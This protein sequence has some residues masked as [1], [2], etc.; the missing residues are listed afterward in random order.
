MDPFT[1]LR[2]A[3]IDDLF[4]RAL[5]RPLD[6]RTAFLRAA[7]GDDPD[8]YHAVVA[9]LESDAAA[10][11]ALGESATDFAAHL[12]DATAAERDRDL[13]SGTRVGPYRVEGELGRGG[14]GTVYRAAR[15]DGAFEKAVA[16]K[17]VK[18]GMD[19]DELLGRFRYERQIL[20]GLDHPHIARLLDAG[21][22]TDG[23]PYFV[24]ELVEGEPITDWAARHDLDARLALFEQV[25][26]AVAY[27]H[28]HLVVH[29]DLKPSNVLVAT[30]TE[31]RPTVKLLDFGIARLLD[32]DADVPRTR[33]GQRIL[34]PEYAAP[35][36]LRG[37]PVTTATDVYALGVLLFQ[38]LTGRRPNAADELPSSAA[39]S[40][41]QRRALRGDLDTLVGKALRD[42]PARRYATAEALRDDLVR[43]RT[44]RP[45]RARP[46]ARLYRARKFVARHRW[47]VGVSI[48]AALA[49][50]VFAVALVVQQRETAR[51]RDIAEAT[52]AFLQD[53]FNTAD[54]F[55]AST[56][57]PDTLRALD[58]L[59]RSVPRIRTTLAEQPL[60]AAQMLHTVGTVYHGLNQLPQADSSLAEAAAVRRRHL[61]ARHPDVAASLHARGLVLTERGAFEEGEQVLREAV[62][63]FGDLDGPRAPTTARVLVALASNLRQQSRH[64]EA[65][66]LLEEALAI[67]H[68][69][70]EARAHT[71]LELGRVTQDAGLLVE[72][73]QHY[74]DAVA[75]HREALPPQHPTLAGSLTGLSDI[76]RERREFDEAEPLIREALTIREATLGPDHVLTA[77]SMHALAMLLRDTGQFDEALAYFRRIGEIDRRRLGPDHPYVGLN[78]FEQGLTHARMD[79]YAEAL[80][81]YEE[82]DAAL[83]RTLPETHNYVIEVTSGRGIAHLRM[84]A[85]EQAEPLLRRV[86]ALRTEVNGPDSWWTGI[87][88]S[89]LG[90]CLMV[91]ERYAEA[92]PLLLSGYQIVRDA[93]G[94][95]PSTL[96]RLAAF[97]DATG[98]PDEAE[99]Y[100]ALL[101][102]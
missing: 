93:N 15:A 30:G 17:L 41:D 78:L 62:A 51:E 89:A 95:V 94:P 50:V 39:A 98:Q 85:P 80:R 52:V 69:D 21:A 91:Q 88:R 4:A 72:T 28:R 59:D 56:E 55:A 11:E 31:G 60:V 2:W 20:A 1:S 102:S 6:E 76:L 33:V 83:R 100:R 8:L 90:E 63:L 87:A 10:E 14:M 43:R 70:A 86:V 37:E 58:L 57:R 23:R 64:D 82:A 66:P 38:L 79:A 101:G 36:Q 32:D 13:T 44:G 42:D 22:H 81:R 77:S 97:Y 67:P 45:L 29:R 16:L 27:A 54:P 18:R 84:G 3:E 99:R 53:L 40:P 25:C 92:E 26:E 7:C 35:E 75:L 48:A 12:L 24:M 9:L 47:G 61:G 74:R 65:R 5:D 34:T 49:L 73:E 68:A 46:D 19:T 96:R 71:L